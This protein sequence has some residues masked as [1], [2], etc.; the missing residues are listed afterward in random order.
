MEAVQRRRGRPARTV[1]DV[2]GTGTIQEAARVAERHLRGKI[3]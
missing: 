2:D 1:Q 3:K